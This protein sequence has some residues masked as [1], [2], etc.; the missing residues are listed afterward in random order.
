MTW[1]ADY[2]LTYAQGADANSGFVDVGAWVSIINQSGANFDD[3]RLKLIA[4]DV[5]RVQPQAPRPVAQT[6]ARRANSAEAATFAEQP[7]FEYHL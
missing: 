3:A 1:W 6:L 2:N 5:Q 7:F 4:G